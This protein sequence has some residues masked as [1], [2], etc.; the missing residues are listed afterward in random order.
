M[1]APRAGR[2]SRGD[3]N[4]AHSPALPQRHYAGGPRK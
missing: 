1:L 2:M 4:A 3:T